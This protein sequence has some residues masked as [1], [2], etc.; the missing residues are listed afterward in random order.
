MFWPGCNGGA[1]G[2]HC[3]GMCSTV[4]T[5]ARKVA[6]WEYAPEAVLLVGLTVFLI[7]QT[8]AATSAFKSTKALVIMG[9][10]AVGW[11]AARAV[12]ARL[13]PFATARAAVFSVAAAVALS[14]VVLP[15]YDNET[16]VEAFPTAT[17]TA[18]AP[19]PAPALSSPP[20]STPTAASTPDAA[21]G[22]AVTSS[23]SHPT[24]PAV[25][26]A[27]VSMATPPPAAP[28]LSTSTTTP[29]D[30][31]APSAPT[32]SPERATETDGPERL[33]S[34][35]IKGID[36]RASGTAAIYR[37]PDGR[38]VV[39]LEDI[40]IQPGPDYDLYLVPGEGR[41]DTTGGVRLGDLR[42]NRGTQFYEIPDGVDLGNGPWTVLVWCQ[43]FAVPVAGA[44]PT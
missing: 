25:P 29:P 42:G 19:T 11:L 21:P 14:A 7:D 44:T 34:G 15:A 24:R 22:Q 28:E 43:T 35:P 39:G 30:T 1:L 27:A 8:E 23:T 18:A 12:L 5:V 33:R 9:V 10:A 26:A 13:L 17:A 32:A 2:A 37:A 31:A 36:H 38:Y 4:A 40:D 20:R 6:R 41:E 3:P 16:V